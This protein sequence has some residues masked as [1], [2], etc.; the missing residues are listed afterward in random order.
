MDCLDR[1]NVVQSVLSRLLV[2]KQLRDLGILAQDDMRDC[3]EAS[4]EFERVF[5]NSWVD[6]REG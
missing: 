1:T 3:V 6:E 2:N 4:G 5:K